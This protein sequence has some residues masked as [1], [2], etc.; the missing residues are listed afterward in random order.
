MA[1]NGAAPDDIVVARVRAPQD[2]ALVGRTLGDCASELGLPWAELAVD[3]LWRSRGYVDVVVFGSKLD[4]QRRILAHDKVM[5]GSDGFS[6]SAD[7]PAATHPRAFGAFPK[8]LRLLV[9]SGLPWER[10]IAKATGEPAA[11]LGLA[12]RGELRPGARADITV[13]DPAELADQATYTEPLRPATG[14]RHVL[15]DGVAVLEDGRQ[16]GSRPGR[17]LLRA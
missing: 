6:I 3:L 9:D 7:Y 14:V 15:V 10:A 17:V 12:G 4:E 16:T 2:A 5:I 1:A 8:A 13:I 11:K